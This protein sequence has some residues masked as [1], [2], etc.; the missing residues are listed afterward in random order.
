M[1]RWFCVVCGYVHEGDAPPD[2]C[3]VCGV[4]PEEFERIDVE[5]TAPGPPAVRRIVV[6]GNGAAGHHAAL[7]ARRTAPE[8]SV[9]LLAAE[10]H[11]FYNRL[12]LTMFLAGTGE[13]ERLFLASPDT[14]REQ[15]LEVHTG[16][17]VAALRLDRTPLEVATRGGQVFACD[18]LV[19]CT[20]ARP[21][22]PSFPGR[23][24]PGVAVLRT[25][26]DADALIA[27]AP[28]VARA[29]VVGGGLLGLEAA[30]GLRQRGVG[31]VQVLE[32]APR[33]LPRQLDRA[34][35]A[36]FER[37]V[38]ALGLDVRTGAQL[39]AVEDGPGAAQVVRL[40][41]GAAL[42]CDL[43]LLAAG[44]VPETRLA[45][46]AGLE[47]RRGVVVDDALRT[48][49]PSVWAAGDCAEHRGVV[50]GLWPVAISMGAVAGANAAGGAERLGEVVQATFLKVLG[51]PLFSAGWTAE[52]PPGAETLAAVDEAAGV[53]RQLVLL[54]GKVVGGSLVGDPARS[55]AVRNAVERHLPVNDRRGDPG[56]P[57]AE[58]IERILSGL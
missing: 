10:P 18:R 53:Y 22:V 44:I 34:G 26:D 57:P 47:V 56:A 6:V 33:L 31:T 35:A 40:A 21:F 32:A 16:D 13:R 51:I 11:R 54:D 4:G 39:T 25:L 30:W 45:A 37:R 42:P 28:G 19:L 36:L 17:P 46:A 24:R 58:Q 50:H 27:R 8:A 7:A 9:R 15:R 12:G 48:S 49:H 38:R 14:D 41:D 29:V 55:V 5:A 52:P 2:V 3:P 23:D 43:V 20:G 1:A